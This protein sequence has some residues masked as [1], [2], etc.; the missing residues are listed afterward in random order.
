[1]HLQCDVATKVGSW[2]TMPGRGEEEDT[3]IRVTRSLLHPCFKFGVKITGVFGPFHPESQLPS[4]PVYLSSSLPSI[5][6]FTLSF[7]LKLHTS[8]LF[9]SQGGKDRCS[10]GECASEGRARILGLFQSSM[11]RRRERF[12]SWIYRRGEGCGP[13]KTSVPCLMTQGGWRA[14]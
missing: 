14:I 2:Q 4:I 3:S 10:A 7:S 6:H 12:C 11:D 13:I 5:S 8:L 9:L 1:M